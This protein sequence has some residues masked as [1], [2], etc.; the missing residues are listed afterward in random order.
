MP[1]PVAG[2][3]I[4]RP[5]RCPRPATGAGHPPEAPVSRLSPRPGVSPG[6]ARFPTVSAVLL[7][8]QPAAQGL[9]HATL[10]ILWPSTPHPQDTRR[11][12]PGH[13]ACPPVHPQPDAQDT[14]RGRTL[15]GP[16]AGGVLREAEKLLARIIGRTPVP[17]AFRGV[18]LAGERRPSRLEQ[19]IINLVVNARDPCAP[20]TIVTERVLMAPRLDAQIVDRKPRR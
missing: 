12:P 19:V 11:Y 6:G 9:Y 13:G 10:K 15:T 1:K 8:P 16:P 7:A 14:R 18:P 4:T 17:L 20:P 5:P 3:S 2:R